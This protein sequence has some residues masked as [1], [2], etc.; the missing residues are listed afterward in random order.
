MIYK[1][2]RK[3]TDITTYQVS[4]NPKVVV[5]VHVYR[6]KSEWERGRDRD[7]DT[8]TE[9]ERQRKRRREI[10]NIKL[11]K[12]DIDWV[13]LVQIKKESLKDMVYLNKTFLKRRHTLYFKM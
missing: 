13:I 8:K 1:N 5:C 12:I 6:R 3:I 2:N 9:T 4:L 10:K 11:M 7:R